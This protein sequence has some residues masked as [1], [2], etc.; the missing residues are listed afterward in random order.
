MASKLSEIIIAALTPALETIGESKL[1]ALLQ[2]IHDKNPTMFA[3][4]LQG[5]HSLFV[6]LQSEAAT[7]KTPIDDA[8][9]GAVVEAI[10]ASAKTNSVTLT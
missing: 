2:N 5:A 4:R 9:A 1:E 8:V 3:T 10:E 6:E 7:S